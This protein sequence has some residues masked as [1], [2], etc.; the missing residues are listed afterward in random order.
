MKLISIIKIVKE[1]GDAGY[2][3]PNLSHA[4]QANKVSL[5]L[6]KATLQLMLEKNEIIEEDYLI[7]II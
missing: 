4:K 5:D 3:F 7:C 6:I 2:W 1:M